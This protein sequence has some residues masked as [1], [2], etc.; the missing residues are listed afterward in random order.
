LCV[1][2]VFIQAAAAE[3]LWVGHFD[4]REG[5]LPPGWKVEHL[6]RA[7][8]P[9]QYRLRRWDGVQAVEAIAEK[10]M[11]VLTR[12]IAVD[13]DKTPVLCWRWRV[14]GPVVGADL[15]QKPGDD[16][17]ARVYLTFAVPPEALD[18]ATRAE[19]AIARSIWGSQLPDA[20][21]IYI[22]D[23]KYPVGTERPNAY[24]DRA[25]MIVVESG[26]A[27]AGRWVAERR[28]VAADF[29][30]AFRGIPGRLTGIAI[31]SDTDDTG[32]S[33]HAGFAD[34]HFI[35]HRDECASR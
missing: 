8:P 15:A 33:A 22:W 11:A 2:A 23:N 6:D 30:R 10:S 3:P 35:A 17:A 32:G 34:L 20:A 7:F 14:D 26:K 27:Q 4:G 21:L 19:L 31:A 9:T 16:Y 25:R 1:L 18:V 12:S 24:S 28:D 5:G 13:L 29:G